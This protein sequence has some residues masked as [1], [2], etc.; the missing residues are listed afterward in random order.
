MTSRSRVKTGVVLVIL[1]VSAAPSKA[2]DEQ[3]VSVKRGTFVFEAVETSFRVENELRIFGTRGFVL[4]AFITFLPLSEA[5]EQCR[6]PGCTPGTVVSLADQWGGGDV[7]FS[8]KLRGV[9]YNSS[10]GL[11][12]DSFVWL[13][14]SGSITMPPMRDG[15]AS[16]T[17]PFELAGLVALGEQGP[18][19][20]RA[21]LAG[22]GLVTVTL[23]PNQLS[24]ASWFIQR[25]VFTFRPLAS[26]R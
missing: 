24:G 23:V 3:V 4:D 16:I 18:D 21:L 5:I 26:R 17:A 20:Q 22:G 11:G 8:A 7:T 14:V 25:L 2:Q 1:A 15:P 19:P 6:F 13:G 9:T 10:G 12:E